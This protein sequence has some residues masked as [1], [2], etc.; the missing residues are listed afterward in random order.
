MKEYLW[1][2]RKE[3][4]L[5][6]LKKSDKNY[7]NEQCYPSFALLGVHARERRQADRD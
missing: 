2:K 1:G 5:R 4:S 7:S 3:R 6:A